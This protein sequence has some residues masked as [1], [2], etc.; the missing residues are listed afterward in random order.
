[1]SGQIRVEP[2]RREDAPAAGALLAASHADYPAFR[3]VFPDGA[4]RQRVLVPFLTASATDAAAFGVSTSV[5]DGERLL[6]VALWLPPGTFP[7]SARRKLRAAPV[8][9]R[10]ALAAPRSFGAFARIGAAAEKGHPQ[11]PHWSLQALG[12]HP[13]LQG[14]GSGRQLML[15]ALRSADADGLP[16]YV[17][18]SDPSNEGFY[19]RRGFEVVEPS[20]EYLPSG[21]RYM[22]LRRAAQT[23]AV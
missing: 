9:T 14:Q 4:Q 23:G 1:M 2:L 16:C 8:L 3:H 13:R 21:P 17:E 11:E 20:L 12:V 18:T 15:P 10:A 7:W 6:G 19:S 22:R 5:W